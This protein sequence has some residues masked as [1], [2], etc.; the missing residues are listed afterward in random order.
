MKKSIKRKKIKY[1]IILK[2][3]VKGRSPIFLVSISA[4]VDLYNN[5]NL[6]Q[7]HYFGFN[8]WF[9]LSCSFSSTRRRLQHIFCSHLILAC[10]DSSIFR[11]LPPNKTC[12]CLPL[13]LSVVAVRYTVLTN[14]FNLVLFCALHLTGQGKW[15][16]ILSLAL[17]EVSS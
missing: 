14:S 3:D 15:P 6:I 5:N 8:I 10:Q 4:S 17:L 12:S 13:Q 9:D 7:D 2:R 1:I 11:E 16:P